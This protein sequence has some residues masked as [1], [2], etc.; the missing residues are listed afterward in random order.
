MP[1]KEL[2]QR[3]WGGRF[4]MET[5]TLVASF[6]ASIDV[7]QRM[8]LEDIQGSIAHATMMQEQGI[9]T[10]SETQ[11][12]VEG[13]L[14]VR[15]DIVAGRFE[16]QTSLEDVHMNIEHALIERIGPV[17]GKLHTARRPQRPGGYG[18]AIMVADCLSG[19]C[20]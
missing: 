3:M 18:L 6:G 7:D 20:P 1:E 12:I 11:L 5:D 14:A 19:N 2:G 15:E 13:L 9:L 4:E 17:G 8:A 10:R 16:W